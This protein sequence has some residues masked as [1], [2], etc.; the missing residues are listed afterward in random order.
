MDNLVLPE[1]SE[2][3]LQ[4]SCLLRLEDSSVGLLSTPEDI[5]IDPDLDP[6][7]PQMEKLQIATCRARDLRAAASNETIQSYEEMK[8]DKHF[9]NVLNL[10]QV[11]NVHTGLIRMDTQ[12]CCFFQEVTG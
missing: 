10:R 4:A 2:I 11:N 3:F 1:D 7:K 5:Q 9:F 8:A 6:T 12:L